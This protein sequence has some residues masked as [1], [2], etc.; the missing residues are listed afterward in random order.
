VPKGAFAYQLATRQWIDLFQ[1]WEDQIERLAKWIATATA[2]TSNAQASA[3][4]VIPL[5]DRPAIDTDPRSQEETQRLAGEETQRKKDEADAQRIAEET[6]RQRAEAEWLAREEKSRRQMEVE[7]RQRAEE[8]RLRHEADA[9][10]RADQEQAYSAAKLADAVSAMD[11]F[12]AAYPDSHLAGEA[13]ALRATLIARDETKP[14][15]AGLPRR[16]LYKAEDGLQATVAP[17][18]KTETGP[19]T[20]SEVPDPHVAVQPPNERPT[21]TAPPIVPTPPNEPSV[22]PPLVPEPAATAAK[23]SPLLIGG[24]VAAVLAVV[25]VIAIFNLSGSGQPETHSTAPSPAPPAATSETRSPAV[26]SA[27]WWI[28]QGDGARAQGEI[29]LAISDY[30]MAQQVDPSSGGMQKAAELRQGQSSGGGGDNTGATMNNQAL[31]NLP[32]TMQDMLKQL[33]NQNAPSPP[34][35]K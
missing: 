18:P 30:E 19:G 31:Q 21:I 22:A 4:P 14:A 7:A 17:P 6:R 35:T 9:K 29:E 26:S 28:Q 24:V 34:E 13:K 16:D 27:A 3:A 20:L 5:P 33:M 1:D 10:R 32:Q 2:A 11:K 12:L 25:G 8:E 15:A 23:R